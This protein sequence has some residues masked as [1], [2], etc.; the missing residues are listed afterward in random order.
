MISTIFDNQGINNEKLFEAFIKF[1]RK[2]FV[3]SQYAKYAYDDRPL[4]IGHNATIS[5]PTTVLFMLIN[6]SVELGD[7]VLEIG[8]GSGWQTAIL[9]DLVGKNGKVVAYE[10]ILQ[11]YDFGKENL[12]KYN[13]NNI[14]LRQGNAM[15]VV[16]ENLQFDR[17]I[18]GA[19]FN[20]IPTR[21]LEKLNN[22]GKMVVPTQNNDVLVMEKDKEGKISQKIFEGFIFVPI[23]NEQ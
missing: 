12:K 2:D 14:E 10:I 5:Q 6:L 11:L 19:A 18:A 15:A 22:G 9:S 3:V 4:P 20:K 13:L 16:D 8:F 23:Q 1:D 21:L 17:I 7:T